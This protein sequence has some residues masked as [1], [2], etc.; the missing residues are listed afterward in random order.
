MNMINKIIIGLITVFLTSV[1]TTSVYQ[2]VD[3]WVVILGLISFIVSASL[4][5]I[6]VGFS[7]SR[8]TIAFFFWALYVTIIFIP[9]FYYFFDSTGPYRF[10]F[11]IA[12]IS[13]LITVPVGMAFINLTSGFNKK[14][15]AHYFSLPI[16]NSK[17]MRIEAAKYTVVLVIALLIAFIYLQE[18]KT[19]PLFYML[20][21]PGETMELARL[22][23]MSLKILDSP[24]RFFYNLLRDF[25]FPILV[26]YS[27]S[28]YLLKRQKI[29]M[30]LFI[31]TFVSGIL[32]ASFSIARM[33]PAVI[34]FLMF[35]WWHIFYKKR[36]RIATTI[37]A[38]LLIFTFPV[39]VL[40]IT[41]P[42]ESISMA[43]RTTVERVIL[44]P[45]HTLYYYFEIF[46]EKLDYLYGAT[47]GKLTFL[48][49]QDNFN[50]G[51]YVYKYIIP[52]G[53]E[54]GSANAAFIGNLYADFGIIGVLFGG[55]FVGAM[56][57]TLQIVFYNKQKDILRTVIYVYAVYTFGL[58]TILPLT[59]VFI[60]SGFPLILLF[61]L[62]F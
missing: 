17:K 38:V 49:G 34:I 27:F 59:A 31:F 40:Q 47:G 58:L 15:V 52:R 54:T 60:Y 13:I 56:M 16:E 48:I 50:I 29:W 33:P 24:L 3:I 22:R 10:N 19:I 12:V 14:A 21:H 2:N 6:L 11:I 23:D 45:S 25:L 62:L 20:S 35:F 41:I 57:Q 46:P 28:R 42:D 30:Y 44:A 43:L 5:Y 32:Y 39:I 55:I 61:L 37:L 4:I 8:I 53:L 26:M 18:V 1:I 36:K 9:S 7:F 51:N